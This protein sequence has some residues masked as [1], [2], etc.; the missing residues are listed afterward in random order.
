MKAAQ[1]I[2]GQFTVT[3]VAPPPAAGP[4]QLRI[5]VAAC[6]ICGSDLS[7]SK[8]PCRFVSVAAGAGYPF[9][10]FDAT[11]PV[12]LGH[13]WSGTVVET[14]PGVE[15]FAAGDRVTGLGITTEQGTGMPTIIGYSN[16]YHGAFGEEIVVDAFWVRHVPDGLSLEHA[17]LAEP[18][19]VGEMHMQ[20]SGLSA[21]DTAL[22]IGCGS[23][24]LGTILA[25]KAAGAHLVIAS[26][27]S[28]K[29]RELA[30][31]MGADIVVDPN[32]QDPIAVYN[33]LL[34]A[35][36]TGGGILI[37]YECSGRVGTLNSLTHTLPWG[38]RIQVVASPFNEE[39]IIPVVAQMRQIAINFGHGPYERAYEKV[40]QRLA[41]GEIDAEALITGRT[42]LDGIGEA[43]DALRNPDEH[44]KILVLPS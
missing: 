12:V 11:R 25:A 1:F 28:P 6:G 21:T 43:F 44:V 35:G 20:Q 34:G 31:K 8:D 9:A 16:D 17:T 23:I 2:E 26:E 7:M 39:T 27:P 24:G 29:R 33:E 15:D 3:D 36:K 5:K 10:V 41:D 40:L 37:A 38:S 42:G 19:H 18:L 4:G 22:V 14:G 32:E 30:A 13:E